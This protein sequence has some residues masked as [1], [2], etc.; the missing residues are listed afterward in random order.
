RSDF[1]LT[2]AFRVRVAGKASKTALCRATAQPAATV[3]EVARPLLKA[4]VAL[5]GNPELGFHL[6]ISSLASFIQ[7]CRSITASH[8]SPSALSATTGVP[9]PSI[10][11]AIQS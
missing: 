8:R 2:P 4:L 6:A 5:L 1:R 9:F 10:A 3:L 11:C 7:S